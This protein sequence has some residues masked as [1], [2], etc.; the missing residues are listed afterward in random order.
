MDE[1]FGD[2]YLVEVTIVVGKDRLGTDRGVLW[3]SDG[4]MGFSGN[5]TSFVLSGEDIRLQWKNK[6][7]DTALPSHAILLQ[8]APRFAYFVVHPI[9]AAARKCFERLNLFELMGTKHEGERVWPPL[10]P[11]KDGQTLSTARRQGLGS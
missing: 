9:G 6:K 8:G 3:F 1:S 4:L 2:Q 5:A 11:Y 10:V 7:R